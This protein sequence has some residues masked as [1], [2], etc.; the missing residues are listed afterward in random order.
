MSE[1]GNQLKTYIESHKQNYH[2]YHQLSSANI[3][4]VSSS[5]QPRFCECGIG[6]GLLKQS[7][8]ICRLPILNKVPLHIVSFI[9]YII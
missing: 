5:S 9:A 4:T 7:I 3:E 2:Q 6:D 1:Y 8:F